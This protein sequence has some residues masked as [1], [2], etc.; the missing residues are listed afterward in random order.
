[1]VKGMAKMILSLAN[2]NNY[3]AKNYDF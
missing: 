3:W 2:R 1:L